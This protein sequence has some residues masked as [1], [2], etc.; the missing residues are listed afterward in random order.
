M[1]LADRLAAARE[2]AAHEPVEPTPLTE[3]M[4]QLGK[5]DRIEEIKGTVHAELLQQLGPQLYDADMDH[6]ELAERVHAVL[7]EVLGAQ[8]KPLSHRDRAR[9]TQEITDDILG[10][11]P[12][13][14]F[15]RD[16]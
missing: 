1:T 11:G 2:D 10:Y 13:E 7:A 16:P 15:L 4:S 9:V 6:E 8:E 3:R 5:Q 12:I 14:P